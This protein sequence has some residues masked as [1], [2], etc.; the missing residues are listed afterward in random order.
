M[1]FS[2]KGWHLIKGKT[3]MAHLSH[4]P[5]HLSVVKKQAMERSLNKCLISEVSL[6]TFTHIT[7]N[8][9]EV[10]CY[11][12]WYY[13]CWMSLNTLLSIFFFLL[14]LDFYSENKMFAGAA[15]AVPKDSHHSLTSTSLTLLESPWRVMDWTEEWV[16]S[17]TPAHCCRRVLTF[18]LIIIIYAV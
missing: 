9:S 16:P 2:M 3:M 18:H 14:E 5:K 8:L 4:L 11:K 10:W 13:C 12:P 7:H 15:K 1:H 6:L 17:T